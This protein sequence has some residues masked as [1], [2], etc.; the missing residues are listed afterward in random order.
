MYLNLDPNLSTTG[1]EV[2]HRIE[3]AKRILLLYTIM[4]CPL[5]LDSLRNSID[6]TQVFILGLNFPETRLVLVHPL[7]LPLPFPS[8][9]P[10]PSPLT[11]TNPLTPPP[12][13][14]E[15]NPK[16][17][18]CRPPSIPPPAR[19]PAHPPHRAPQLP[20]QPSRHRHQRRAREPEDRKRPKERVEAE[21]YAV[22]GY[23]EL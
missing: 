17:L 5:H 6:T 19:A 7:P 11:K 16:L 23:G 14:L 15:N 21:Y 8:L 18:W 10:L 20:H 2:L 1:S 22:E 13:P 12:S 9:S 4:V 3:A